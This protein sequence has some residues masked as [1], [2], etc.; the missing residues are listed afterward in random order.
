[1][2]HR[3]EHCTQ[4]RW[5][6]QCRRVMVAI[7]SVPSPKAQNP[8]TPHVTPIHSTLPPP[9][10]RMSGC[11]QN[12]VHWPFKSVLV[13]PVDSAF[14]WQTETPLLFTDKCYVGASSL[15]WCLELGSL[16]W[17]LTPTL[18]RENTLH[19]RCHSRTSATAC[20]S[21]TC[22]FHV[23]TSLDVVSSVNP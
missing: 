6:L 19:P 20:G 9:E 13:S 10:L 15:L 2:P 18:L 17:G 7:S 5:H 22:S 21:R 1:M 8:D 16:A 4:E 11:E 23:F 14:F 3:G 12:F